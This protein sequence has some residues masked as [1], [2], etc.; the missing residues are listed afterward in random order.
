MSKHSKFEVIQSV[1]QEDDNL[2]SISILCEIAGVSRSGYYR[3]IASA[4]KRTEKEYKDEQDFELILQAYNYRGYPKGAK[5]IYMTLL[6]F[7]P[8]VI[9][10]IKKI[11]RLMSKYN[12]KCPVR[13][14]N[15]YRRI[16]REIKTNN[17]VT[18]I[19]N[20]EFVSHGARKVFLTDITYIQY[21]NGCC[22]LVTILDAYT[23]Q[24]LS[25]ELSESLEIDFVLEAV[26]KLVKVHKITLNSEALI[27][28]DQGCHFT[29]IKFIKLL[30]D[31]GLRQSMSRKANCW[32]NAPQESF[33]G[34]MK[35]EINISNCKSFKEVKEVIDDWID[36]YNNDRYQWQ[37]SKLSPNEYYEYITTGIYPLKISKKQ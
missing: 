36:Y 2:L 9:M 18:N 22:Y 13:C 8:P 14:S 21:S 10:N 32:D 12:L 11:R 19:L 6:H 29:S 25:Y 34:H 33:F 15:P 27:H 17:T 20:R 35:D 1:L 26:K 7:S 4:E 23:R 31:K 3:W 5:G 37:L 24:V 28:S 16:A 30:K